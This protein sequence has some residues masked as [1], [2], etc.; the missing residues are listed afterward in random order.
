VQLGRIR[1]ALNDLIEGLDERPDADPAGNETEKDIVAASGAEQRLPKEPAPDLT[2]PE[3]DARP[4]EWRSAH[5]VLCIGGRWPF[6][7]VVAEILAQLLQKHAI[8]ARL[9]SREAVSRAQIASLDMRGD[10]IV[11]IG[12]LERAG[13]PAE[14]RYVVRRIRSRLPGTTIVVGLW[15]DGDPILEDRD[16]QKAVGADVYVTSLREAVRAC[17]ETARQ[18]SVGKPRPTEGIPLSVL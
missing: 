3:E 10:A 15:P 7:G 17:L 13:S 9:L 6:D 5:P 12:Y 14:L 16:R 11:F 2:L 18:A 8:G 1:D 4:P